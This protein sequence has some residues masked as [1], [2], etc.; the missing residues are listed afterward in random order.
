[1]YS[2]PDVVS[3]CES[4]PRSQNAADSKE[5]S[6]QARG[7]VNAIEDVQSETVRGE[8][9]AIR[10]AGK[11]TFVLCRKLF[12]RCY[13]MCWRLTGQDWGSCIFDMPPCVACSGNK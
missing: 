13:M 12:R 1:M 7:G 4:S 3:A 2:V 11:A 8:V 10:H 5:V 6:E 9:V